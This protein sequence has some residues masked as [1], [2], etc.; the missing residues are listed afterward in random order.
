MWLLILELM[1][2]IYLG[3]RKM[4]HKQ[5]YHGIFLLLLVLSCF[6]CVYYDFY[7]IY[8]IVVLIALCCVKCVIKIKNHLAHFKQRETT[9]T[10]LNFT[11]QDYNKEIDIKYTDIIKGASYGFLT[12]KDRIK[13]FLSSPKDN[14]NYILFNNFVINSVELSPICDYGIIFMQKLLDSNHDIFCIKVR[15]RGFFVPRLVLEIKQ[16]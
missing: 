16:C 11:L 6:L 14:K 5:N 8:A 1:P 2:E 15:L 9:P 10:R 7:R 4:Y 3:I 12:D 13:F